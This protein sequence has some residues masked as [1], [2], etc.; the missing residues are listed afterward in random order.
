MNS[1][2]GA[3]RWYADAPDDAD[4]RIPDEFRDCTCFLCV[5][6]GD[7]VKPGGTAFL[8]SFPVG[9]LFTFHYLVTAK[10]CVTKAL[11]KYGELY[12]RI[13]TV[14]G[15]HELVKLGRSWVY[16]DDEGVDVAVMPWVQDVKKYTLGSVDIRSSAFDGNTKASAIGIGNELLVIGLFT[17]HYGTK[18][19]IPIVRHGMLAS[20]PEEPLK[21]ENTGDPFRAYLAEIQSI[22]GLS[23][24]PVFVFVP[25]IQLLA[26][27]A[28]R[29]ERDAMRK[30]W[31]AGFLYL[32]GLVRGHFDAP[33]GD[34][35][36][37]S[38]SREKVHYGVAMVTPMDEVLSIMTH[39]EDLVKSRKERV[40]EH[41]RKLSSVQT[42]DSALDEP[43]GFTQAG[44]ETALRKAGRKLKPKEK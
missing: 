28:N 20:M 36:D 25:T 33:Q 10:H 29:D 2:W 43:N 19:N 14:A 8:V 44:F 9:R 22:G 7:V 15:S 35:I 11:D 40:R 37:G 17:L 5:K 6:D 24:S 27:H 18:R 1:E 12:A 38:A 32:L 30:R 16:S 23:G 26:H 34:W 3:E 13:N 21:D 42:E 4:M 31:P 39:D 41:Q